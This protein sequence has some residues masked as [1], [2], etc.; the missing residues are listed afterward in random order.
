MKVEGA[1]EKFALSVAIGSL[2]MLGLFLIVDARFDGF[3]KAF[4]TYSASSS[5]TVIAAVPAVTIAYILGSFVQ[6]LSALVVQRVAPVAQVE[7]WQ[8]L[9]HLARSGNGILAVEF[10]EIRRSKKLLEGSIAPLVLLAIG[11]FAERSRLPELSTL[12]LWSSILV[13]VSAGSIPFV[14][15]RLHKS[16]VRTGGIAAS[17]QS[18]Q[19][20]SRAQSI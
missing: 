2:L 11:I 19:Q 12:L 8:A 10:E 3:L 18:D 1:I 6:V 16:L 5:W 20:N 15:G 13:L 9:E 7:E 14:A 17:I 4:E